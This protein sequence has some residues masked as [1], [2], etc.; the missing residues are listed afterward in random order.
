MIF[1]LLPLTACGGGGVGDEDTDVDLV[2]ED[3]VEEDMEVDVPVDPPREDVTEDTAD[4]IPDG[5]D[6]TDGV[7]GVDGD[8][9]LDVVEDDAEPDGE[10]VQEEDI[11]GEDVEEEDAVEEPDGTGV[12][13]DGVL[14]PGEECDGDPDRSCA[15]S[16]G[17]T[18]AQSCVDCAWSHCVPPA[19]T[20]NGIDDNCDGSADEGFDCVQGSSVSCT[21]TCGTTGTGTCTDTCLIPAPA[22]CPPPA[23]ICNGVDDDCNGVCDDG[24]DC[25]RGETEDCTMPGGDPGSRTC[26]DDCTWGD[27]VLLCPI[28]CLTVPTS[29]EVGASC[30]SDTDCSGVADCWEETSQHFRG[31]VYVS[32]PGGQCIPLGSGT[33]VCDPDD[34]SSCPSGSTC[35]YFGSAMGTD[36]HGCMDTCIP[37]DSSNRPY[38]FNCGCREGYNCDL[39]LETCM[40]GCSNDRECCERWWDL[41][42]D[43][44]RDAGEVVERAGCTNS[45]NNTPAGLCQAT[46][47]C[48]NNG[49][50]ANVWSGPCEG[51]PWCPPDGRCL[52]EFH[53]TDSDGSPLLPGG[54]CLK[55]ACD[56]VGRGCSDHAGGCLNV[57]TASDPFW[58]CVGKCHFGRNIGDADYE[59][60]TTAGQ[61][62]ACRPV[63][64]S[65][66]NTLPADGSDGFCWPGNFPGG[67]GETGAACADSST[68]VSPYGLGNCQEFTGITAAPFC[69]AECIQLSAENYAICG[70]DDGT[71]TAGGVCWSEI[72]WEGCNNPGGNLGSNGCTQPSDLACY[73]MAMFTDVYKDSVSAMPAG[74][75]IPRCTNN[76]WC[77]DFW[78][79][80]LACNTTSGVCE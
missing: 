61:E 2:D 18:G 79:M 49:D 48:V 47:D 11:A 24:F 33:S 21:T 52:D 66:W 16:C 36:Y 14:D 68:C 40:S 3:V 29:G 32:D 6:V 39:V 57:G 5:E 62:H 45:C 71:G 7:D 31:E 67:A 15:T 78:G 8:D 46:H 37:A 22:D 1:P 75:C 56:L 64:S 51:N 42:G 59:C 80:S 9:A 25:C 69:S 58:A 23:E 13:G 4:V 17:T 70:G 44:Q 63:E 12:C 41:D 76:A 74:M 35:I 19:E 53:Y 72:C 54:L 10:D 30:V 26:A 50:P 60:R 43:F 73:P 27:C 34:P 65:S 77:L 38:P 55:D 20:C 28:E